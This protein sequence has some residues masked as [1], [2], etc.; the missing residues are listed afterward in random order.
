MDKLSLADDYDYWS[1]RLELSQYLGND[2]DSL[3]GKVPITYIQDPGILIDRLRLA[4]EKLEIGNFLTVLERLY[5]TNYSNGEINI[6]T[7]ELDEFVTQ[8]WQKKH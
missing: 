4:F 5:K 3:L 7:Q 6:F 8:R 2:Y 1:K